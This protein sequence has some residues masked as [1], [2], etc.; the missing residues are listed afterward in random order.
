MA[1]AGTKAFCKRN[2]RAPRALSPLPLIFSYKSEKSLCGA[3]HPVDKIE[4]LVL[5]GTWSSYPTAC[6]EEFVRDL[7]YAAN[8]FYQRQKRPR[9]SL[10]EE[11]RRCVLPNLR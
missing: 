11:Q 5:G 9:M 10:A 6:Q 2:R 4:L 7:F 8:T 1:Q 3:G